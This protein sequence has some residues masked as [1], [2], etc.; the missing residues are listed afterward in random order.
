MN[1]EDYLVSAVN[2]SVE[3]GNEIL[4]IYNDPD[5]D[6][7]VE[8]K[9]DNSPVTIAD[10]KAHH[11]I[12]KNLENCGL[13]I[14]SEEGIHSDYKKRQNWEYFFLVDP[15]DGTKEFIKKNGEFTVNI[16]LI[17]KNRPISG[18]VYL[19]VLNLLYFAF[20]NQSY[21]IK[22]KKLKDF[23]NI[24]EILSMAEKISS[25]SKPEKYTIIATRSHQNDE[26]KKF[27]ED[28]KKIYKDLEI[29]SAGSSLKFCKIAEGAAHIY[30]RTGYTM[31]W[32][33]AAGHAVC[34]GAGLKVTDFDTGEELKYNK[35]NL[36]NPYFIV[37]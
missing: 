37:E 20:E 16:A 4:D 5:S 9:E 35:E 15:L 32:D 27:I 3:A 28:K 10:K 14:L 6:F 18:V 1:F 29:I 23:N 24:K 11:T 22:N 13:P 21:K 30:P 34:T 8:K 17:H 2:A 7:S 25:D 33:T 19:P 31:E 26:L 36:K 12:L